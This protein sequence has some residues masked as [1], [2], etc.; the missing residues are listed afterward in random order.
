MD[1][2]G[3]T[4]ASEQNTPDD[5]EDNKAMTFLRKIGKVGGVANKDYRFAMGVDEGPSGKAAGHGG[6]K[7]RVKRGS[8]RN[9]S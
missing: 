6:M 7:V 2:V 1:D 9:V 3:T 5:K 8:L 4:A